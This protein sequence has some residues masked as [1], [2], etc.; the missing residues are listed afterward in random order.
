MNQIKC[1]HPSII[2]NREFVRMLP[3]WLYYHTPNHT[4]SFLSRAR[5]ETNFPYRTFYSIKQSVTLDNIGEYYALYPKTGATVPMFLAVPCGKCDICRDGK[6]KDFVNRCNYESQLYDRPPYFVTLTYD[7][8]HLPAQGVNKRDIQLFF[9]RL[10]RLM[11]TRHIDNKIRY[12]LVAEYGRLRHRPH[13]HAIIWNF[14]LDDIVQFYELVNKAW[15]NG[16]VHT[17]VVK[18]NCAGY[19][20]K[21]IRKL[22]DVPAGKN[23]CFQTASNRGGGIGAKFIDRYKDYFYAYPNQLSVKYLDKFTGKVN[24]LRCIK[25]AKNRLFPTISKYYTYKEFK[26]LRNV[27]ELGN[28]LGRPHIEYP[29]FHKTQYVTVSDKNMYL[30][31]EETEASMVRI[32]NES[33][34]IV[35]N[36]PLDKFKAWP[37]FRLR[38]DLYKA[39]MAQTF[40]QIPECDIVTENFKI[41]RFNYKAKS[42]CYDGQ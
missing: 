5:L 6:A 13:Y 10:R 8:V 23:K 28:I 35:S 12:V 1:S 37:L 15:Q 31:D 4:Q 18:D 27:T 26:A 38:L 9:K 36:I 32:F 30:S 42:I 41:Q 19:C 20:A 17:S 16:F 2:L 40:E 7:N 34:E 29:Y 22:T 33:A 25:Y 39:Y 24:E 3:R 21:Y 14:G 11:E